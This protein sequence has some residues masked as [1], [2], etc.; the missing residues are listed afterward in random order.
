MSEIIIGSPVYVIFIWFITKNT[1]PNILKIIALI[2]DRFLESS[3]QKLFPREWEQ[4]EI[5]EVDTVAKRVEKFW[6]EWLVH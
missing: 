2:E 1:V 6:N 4:Y 3:Y 5:V